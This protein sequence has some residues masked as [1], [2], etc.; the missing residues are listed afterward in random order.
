MKKKKN[1]RKNKN[2][3]NANFSSIGKYIEKAFINENLTL[4]AGTS[5]ITQ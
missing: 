5:V 4:L 3:I 1:K 2:L